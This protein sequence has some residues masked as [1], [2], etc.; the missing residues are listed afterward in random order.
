[1]S[2]ILLLL[3]HQIAEKVDTYALQS[4]FNYVLQQFSYAVCLCIFYN[5]IDIYGVEPRI[6]EKL[7]IQ[8]KIE[9]GQVLFIHV[10]CAYQISFI[11]CPVDGL[12]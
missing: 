5:S 7:K 11:R 2:N 3:R 10:I 8:K 12:Y 9:S 6:K 1:M 4:A